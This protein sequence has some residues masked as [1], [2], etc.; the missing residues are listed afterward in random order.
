MQQL[1]FINIFV[2]KKMRN[3]T[4]TNL[5]KICKFDYFTNKGLSNDYVWYIFFLI[6]M[7]WWVVL[8][9][10]SMSC[11]YTSLITSVYT[12]QVDFISK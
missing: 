1:S 6:N 8:V 9:Q 7:G 5:L 10:K 3:V 11:K 4:L 12:S 2:K